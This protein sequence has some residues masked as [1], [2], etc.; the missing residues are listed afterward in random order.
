M[1][2]LCADEC[3]GA[4][5]RHSGPAVFREKIIKERYGEL[6]V[7]I[8]IDLSNRVNLPL[9]LATA[10]LRPLRTARKELPRKNMRKTLINVGSNI[11]KM[12]C[13]VKDF[14]HRSCYDDNGKLHFLETLFALGKSKF[15]FLFL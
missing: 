9:L 13:Q 2:C 10:G 8:L 12:H 7:D 14:L 5:A 4:V 1:L 15:I 11:S 6:I 3:R